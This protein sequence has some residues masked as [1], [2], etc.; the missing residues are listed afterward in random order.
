MTP[1][2]RDWC[3][4]KKETIGQTEAALQGGRHVMTRMLPFQQGEALKK[5]S[6]DK[7]SD[8]EREEWERK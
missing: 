2:Q 5:S 7:V 6:V 1:I 8:L 3:P 4:Y